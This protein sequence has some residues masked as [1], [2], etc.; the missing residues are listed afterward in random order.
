[1]VWVEEQKGLL[2]SRVVVEKVLMDVKRMGVHGQPVRVQL[3]TNTTRQVVQLIMELGLV[4]IV[5]NKF[6]HP[7]QL[8]INNF[9]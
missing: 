7:P 5:H 2:V 9:L 3:L 4:L 1:L 6:I 8:Y